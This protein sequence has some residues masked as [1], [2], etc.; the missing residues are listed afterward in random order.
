MIFEP[1]KLTTNPT[2]LAILHNALSYVGL[3]EV[4]GK[5]HNN[6]IVGWAKKLASWI[7]DDETS[8]CSIFMNEMCNLSGVKGSGKL[9]AR[10][11]LS[12]GTAI[13]KPEIGCVVIYW[14]NS[15]VGWQGHVGIVISIHDG[16]IETLG[17]NQN[18]RVSVMPY[19]EKRLL[20]YRVYNGN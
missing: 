16:V 4:V 10:S 6:I 1:L 13:E 20:G 15:V 17:G 7:S 11:W 19:D 18:N 3:K 8:W 14:R 5:Q 12:W 2:Q 9:D